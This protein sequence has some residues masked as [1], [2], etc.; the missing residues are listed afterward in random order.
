MQATYEI[1]D[2]VVVKKYPDGNMEKLCLLRDIDIVIDRTRDTLDRMENIL[3]KEIKK[4]DN[5]VLQMMFSDYANEF[6]EL[7]KLS[8]FV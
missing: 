3:T 7:K 8:V 5:S 4:D 1:V 2:E 6:N